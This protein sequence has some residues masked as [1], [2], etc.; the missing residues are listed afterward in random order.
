MKGPEMFDQ[1]Y[2]LTAETQNTLARGRFGHFING[3]VVFGST[4]TFIDTISPATGQVLASLSA[5]SA[6]DVDLAVKAARQAFDG[7]WRGFSP[8][9]RQELLL[10]AVE[11]VRRNYR[12][13]AE[14]ESLDM[15]SPISRT[16]G[17]E[18]AMVARIRYFASL[19]LQINGETIPNGL[20]GEVLSYTRKSAAGVIGGIIPW[21]GPLVAQ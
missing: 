11:V 20:P 13:L 2:D 3:E 14:L 16:L 21:N 12:E 17:S 7:P 4:G 19:A 6:A 10:D 1:A 18:K 15:G 8:Y 5:G 9:Q